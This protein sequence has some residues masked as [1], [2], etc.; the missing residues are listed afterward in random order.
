MTVSESLLS[1]FT[2]E[3]LWA[4]RSRCSLLKSDESEKSN[5]SDS[6]VILSFALK[7]ERFARKNSPCFWQ[8]SLF[9]P[10]LWPRANSSRHFFTHKK[11][12]I[13]KK[14]QRANSQPCLQLLRFLQ[15]W[16]YLNYCAVRVYYYE[17]C[18]KHWQILQSSKS[19]LWIIV[20]ISR[21]T[22]YNCFD[23]HFDHNYYCTV[24]YV[25]RWQLHLTRKPNDMSCQLYCIVYTSINFLP[26]KCF[27]RIKN[28]I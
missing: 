22:T 14:N 3:Q 12:V 16:W 7:I 1:L 11:R 18:K 10:F 21:M 27:V 28:D 23:N 2:K 26:L 25:Q 19:H 15:L 8:F 6:L 4:N 24:L 17:F 13:R 5:V 20:L 9:S